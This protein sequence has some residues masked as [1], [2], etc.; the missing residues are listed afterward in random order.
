MFASRDFQSLATETQLMKSQIVVVYKLNTDLFI[1]F[2][3]RTSNVVATGVTCERSKERKLE[4][5]ARYRT[6]AAIAIS[7]CHEL[8]KARLSLEIS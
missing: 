6:S 1:S 7:K 5:Y 2:A 8:T 4:N 3:W